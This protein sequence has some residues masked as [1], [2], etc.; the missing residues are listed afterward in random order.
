MNLPDAKKSRRGAGITAEEMR[1]MQW[2][3]PQLVVQIRFVEWT[4]EGRLRHAVYVGERPD[5][6][7]KDVRREVTST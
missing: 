1:E 3:K 6:R 7:A 5:K 4:A 2:V